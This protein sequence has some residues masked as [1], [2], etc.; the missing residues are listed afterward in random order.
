MVSR[1]PRSI[2]AA[3]PRDRLLRESGQR[4]RIPFPLLFGPG[5]NPLEAFNS[6][7]AP[8]PKWGARRTPAPILK[9]AGE[10]ALQYKSTVAS[11]SNRHQP[12]AKRS[13]NFRF[14]EPNLKSLTYHTYVILLPG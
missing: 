2:A 6:A 8:P 11:E 10:I 1:P 14:A 3:L 12:K 13:L 7:V 9:C 4:V 5:A